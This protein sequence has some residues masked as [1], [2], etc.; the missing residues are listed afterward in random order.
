VLAPVLLLVGLGLVALAVGALA[1]PW[2]GVL[3]VGVA[4]V[5]VAVIV[6]RGERV[7]GPGPA[8]APEVAA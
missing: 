2:W 6:A 8:P 7:A 1:G 3:A 4:L 5:A